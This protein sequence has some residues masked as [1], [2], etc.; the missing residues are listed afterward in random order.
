[1]EESTRK[2]FLE[3]LR[4]GLW[5]Y[6]PDSNCFEGLSEEDWR[7]IFRMAGKQT[8]IG[9][10][11]Q[12][13]FRLPVACRP[14][15]VVL[16]K[17]IGQNLYV[18]A[19]NR[20]MLQVWKEI[21]S[22]F[23]CEGIQP[24]LMKGFSVGYC[25]A[26]PLSRQAGDIDIFIPENFDKALELVRKWGYLIDHKTHHD[27]FDYK[28]IH[29]EMHP[30]MVIASGQVN[31]ECMPMFETLDGVTLRVPDAHMGSLLLL[32][33]AARHF[34]IGGIGYRYLCD[35]AAYLNYYHAYMDTEKVLHEIRKM[36]LS[37]FVAEFTEVAHREL[38]ISFDG[39][40]RWREG[41]KE[42]YVHRLSEE[43]MEYGDFGA[44]NFKKTT[45]RGITDRLQMVWSIVRRKHYWPR[46]FWK[47]FP[48]FI[49]SRIKSCLEGQNR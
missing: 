32:S 1:M 26:K 13:V 36:G 15:Q 42:K 20:K 18:E 41:A 34:L 45:D 9:V 24:V 47:K 33:H 37:H 27:C 46:L 12:A 7:E 11:I 29:I 40:D 28:G 48:V 14:P 2:A 22:L 49:Y 6:E 10:C 25:Y 4:S 39:M 17:W 3:L 38:G 21:D 16:W 31:M 5:G 44:V 35:W 43:L 30:R 23:V 8:V 19:K